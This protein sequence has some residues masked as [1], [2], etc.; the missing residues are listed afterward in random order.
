MLC[1]MK[2]NSN[3]IELTVNTSCYCVLDLLC[4]KIFENL[5]VV[6]FDE[7]S[8]KLHCHNFLQVKLT[9]AHRESINLGSSLI[10]FRCHIEEVHQGLVVGPRVAPGLQWSNLRR[11]NPTPY[12]E[13]L[14]A[15]VPTLKKMEL[16]FL[17]D[18]GKSKLTSTVKIYL[19]QIYF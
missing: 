6:Q 7:L 14:N 11:M 9:S 17:L 8:L 1:P 3:T 16:S 2:V 18:Q 13:S 15:G 10:F 4:I 12:A 5:G 19:I